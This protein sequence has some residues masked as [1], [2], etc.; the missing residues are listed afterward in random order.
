MPPGS[1]PSK[2]LNLLNLP[3]G[4]ALWRYEEQSLGDDSAAGGGKRNPDQSHSLDTRTFLTML[5]SLFKGSK[6]IFWGA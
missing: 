3:K 2:L 4:S 6:R 5:E 1:E